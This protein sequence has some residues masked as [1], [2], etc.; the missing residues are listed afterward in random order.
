MKEKARKDG[1]FPGRADLV[2]AMQI[3]MRAGIARD[4]FLCAV[5][6]MAELLLMG[7]RLCGFRMDSWRAVAQ[8]GTQAVFILMGE[9]SLDDGAARAF[10][11]GE[12]F[13]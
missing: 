9:G 5:A 13:V 1:A 2:W 6:A 10:K 7:R 4:G 3:G 11:F 8:C 12:G